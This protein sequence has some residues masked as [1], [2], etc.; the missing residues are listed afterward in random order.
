MER[1]Q[2]LAIARANVIRLRIEHNLQWKEI[3]RRAEVSEDSLNNLSRGKPVSDLVLARVAQVFGLELEQLF[4]NPPD[5]EGAPEKGGIGEED[6]RATFR[7]IERY[8]RSITDP[9]R[10]AAVALYLRSV[11]LGEVED[12]ERDVERGLDRRAGPG[13]RAGGA[14][15]KPGAGT[16]RPGR[17]K[18]PEG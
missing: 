2:L 17:G 3:A 7:E 4:Y 12:F 14:P 13:G 5:D 10:R 15:G 9:E 11:A 16:Q 1:S 8:V 6:W 18:G